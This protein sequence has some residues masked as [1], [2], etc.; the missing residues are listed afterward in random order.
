MVEVMMTKMSVGRIIGIVTEKN[1]RTREA[2]SMIAASNR[3]D[4]MA[5]IAARMTRV[6][7]PV[8]R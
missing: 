5:C 7:Y 3:S 8:Q 1:C 6:V 4:G 2:P